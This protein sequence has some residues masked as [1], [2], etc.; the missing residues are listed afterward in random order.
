MTKCLII[1]S[2]C[3]SESDSDIIEYRSECINNINATLKKKEN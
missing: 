3:S 1:D 2:D